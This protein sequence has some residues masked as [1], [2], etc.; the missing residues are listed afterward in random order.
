MHPILTETAKCSS[1]PQLHNNITWYF[2]LHTI[3]RFP[4]IPQHGKNSYMGGNTSESGCLVYFIQVNI[5][6]EILIKEGEKWAKKDEEKRG[7]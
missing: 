5:S 3:L 4:D 6:V 1:L 7:F 2:I